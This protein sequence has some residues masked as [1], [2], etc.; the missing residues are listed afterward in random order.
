MSTPVGTPLFAIADGDVRHAGS[1][2]SYDEPVII[3]RHYRPGFTSCR[4]GGGCF[5]AMY[6]HNRLSV[7]GGC[8]A[9]STGDKVVAGQLLGYSGASASGYQHLHFEIR[10]APPD[11]PYS[12]W[13]RDCVHPLSVLPYRPEEESSAMRLYQSVSTEV[14]VALSTLRRDI[15]G[16]SLMLWAPGGTRVEQPGDTPDARGYNVHPAS[17]ML[18]DW[19]FQWTHKDSSSVPWESW[20]EGG[21]KECPFRA[22]HDESYDPNVHLD[23]ALPGQP[24]VGSFNGV[25]IVLDKVQFWDEDR[26]MMNITFQELTPGFECSTVFVHFANG[27][28]RWRKDC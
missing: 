1:H 6:L 10:D 19:N 25:E 14:T 20:E 3:I 27:E 16:L 28:F 4:A 17:M 8:C 24:E 15:L 26:F 12:Y 18:N 2:S 9:V 21:S 5:H 23:Q 11:D 7:D 22:D 13:Q